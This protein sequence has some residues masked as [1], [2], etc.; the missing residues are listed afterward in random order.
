MVGQVLIFDFMLTS[1]GAVHTSE[2]PAAKVNISQHAGIFIF[3][4]GKLL[5]DFCLTRIRTQSY[6]VWKQG[7]KT[8][9]LN[10]ICQHTYKH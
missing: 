7:I 9:T 8:Q 6:C 5:L 3:Q 4:T 10:I 1:C 2:K